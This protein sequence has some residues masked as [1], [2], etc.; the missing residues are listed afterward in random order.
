MS[1]GNLAKLRAA[2]KTQNSISLETVFVTDAIKDTTDKETW[3]TYKPKTP[4][5]FS[6]GDLVIDDEGRYLE[7]CDVL[8]TQYACCGRLDP[9]KITFYF[10]TENRLRQDNG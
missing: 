9:D 7:V 2:L 4:D 6:E 3:L 1:L 10:K 8:A 5:K